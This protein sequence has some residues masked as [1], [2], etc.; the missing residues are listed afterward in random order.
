LC[1]MCADKRTAAGQ[2][3]DPTEYFVFDAE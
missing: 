3:P 1:R 2:P